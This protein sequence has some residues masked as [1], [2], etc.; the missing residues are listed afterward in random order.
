[1]WPIFVL[2]PKIY[3]ISARSS[4]LAWQILQDFRIEVKY[5]S[6]PHLNVSGVLII[7]R[8]LLG[9]ANTQRLGF[10]AGNIAFAPIIPKTAGYA[11]SLD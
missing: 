1:M 11:G 10:L 4:K 7:E 8:I 5:A 2:L 6:W 9:H 3:I